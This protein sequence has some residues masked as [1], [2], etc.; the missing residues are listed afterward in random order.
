MEGMK[1]KKKSTQEIIGL[2]LNFFN[3]QVVIFP[4]NE[5]INLRGVVNNPI[6]HH[7]DVD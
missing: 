1:N 4:K 2:R 5:T 7:R 6:H 3:W